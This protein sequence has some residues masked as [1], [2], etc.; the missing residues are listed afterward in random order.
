MKS[1]EPCEVMCTFLASGCQNKDRK[2]NGA[3]FA[4]FISVAVVQ[5]PNQNQPQGEKDLFSLQV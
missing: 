3:C 4:S 2:E 5:Y 1:Y